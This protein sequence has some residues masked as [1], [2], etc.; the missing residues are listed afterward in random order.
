M[1]DLSKFLNVKCIRWI[2]FRM[3]ISCEIVLKCGANLISSYISASIDIIIFHGIHILATCIGG[4]TY[5]W[6][7][8]RRF[9]LCLL[10][11][12]LWSMLVW[13]DTLWSEPTARTVTLVTPF[14]FSQQR[15]EKGGVG[16]Q[17]TF[18]RWNYLT[19]CILHKVN[20]P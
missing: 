9:V 18:R 4:G 2:D 16:L 8:D 10:C 12:L 17:E 19:L 11:R 7:G 6:T 13:V 5:Y 14:F 1:Q 15:N 20:C 3:W